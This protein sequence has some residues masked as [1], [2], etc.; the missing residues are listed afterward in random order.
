MAFEKRRLD[1]VDI[2]KMICNIWY[3]VDSL[4]HVVHINHVDQVNNIDNIEIL[5]RLAML[6]MLTVW[7]ML[8]MLTSKSCIAH[9]LKTL[10]RQSEPISGND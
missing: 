2:C 9:C 7:T 3:N 5:M 8:T 6:T 4:D 10:L 1:I